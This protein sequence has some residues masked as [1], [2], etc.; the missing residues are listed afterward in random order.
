MLTSLAARRADLRRFLR[1]E[2]AAGAAINGAITAGIAW[3]V[4]SGVDPVPVWGLGGLVFDL[5]PSTVLPVLAMGLLLP[6]VLRKR[7]AGGGLP[8][9]GWSDLTGWSQFVPRGVVTHAVALALVWF[10]LLAPV[11]AGLLWGGGWNDAPLSVVLLGKALY[12]ALVGA[13]V[14]PAILLPALCGINE[15]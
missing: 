11:A 2:M 9:C 4:F 10:T 15:H 8:A 14:T 1:V 12:G 7:R 6:V 3:L 13:S 5:L